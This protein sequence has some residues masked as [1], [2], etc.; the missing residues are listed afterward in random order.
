MHTRDSKPKHNYAIR[1]YNAV[2]LDRKG[3][4]GK[5]VLMLIR[6]SLPSRGLKIPTNEESEIVGAN[7]VI[8]DDRTLRVFNVYCPPKKSLALELEITNANCLVVV[9]ISTA[10]DRWGYAAT[11]LRFAEVED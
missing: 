5:G 9:A 6:S 2:R 8:G 10:T 4:K 7:I 3:Y 11:D 1:G